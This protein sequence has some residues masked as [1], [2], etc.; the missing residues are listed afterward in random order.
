MK[1]KLLTA[2]E[3]ACILYRV[4]GPARAWEDFLADTRRGKICG[5]P[6]LK[7]YARMRRKGPW[8]PVYAANDIRQFIVEYQIQYPSTKTIA[9]FEPEIVEVDPSDL[10]H[11]KARRLKP[12]A[13]VMAAC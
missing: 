6:L 1:V 10:R 8:L 5:G 13:A 9:P 12:T 7:P 2:P 3:T 11:W 4:F